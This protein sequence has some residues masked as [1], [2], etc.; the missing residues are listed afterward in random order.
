MITQVAP[1]TD[2]T[3]NHVYTRDELTE[4]IRRAAR[5]AS[6]TPE[7][8]RVS[9]TEMEA[10]GAS[11]GLERAHLKAAGEEVFHEG[12]CRRRLAFR[13]LRFYRHLA[14]F[15]SV[16]GGLFVLDA[17]EP[18]GVW[19]FFY[20]MIGWGIGLACHGS[21][22][23]LAEKEAALGIEPPEERGARRSAREERRDRREE[24]RWARGAG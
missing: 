13:R 24:R 4:I 8:D 20:P 7:D 2:S 22:V 14:A 23:Y 15:G 10:I 17:L 12:S 21:R 1:A 18:S 5:M 11:L 16:V 9:E 19:W 3:D 6:R